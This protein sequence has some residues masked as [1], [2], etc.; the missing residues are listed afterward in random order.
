MNREAAERCSSTDIIVV[1]SG[2]GKKSGP[3]SLVLAKT[4]HTT[5]ANLFRCVRDRWSRTLH[6]TLGHVLGIMM[7]LWRRG[8]S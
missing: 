7:L 8:N 5:G 4:I 2:P 6:Y 1:A 3:A